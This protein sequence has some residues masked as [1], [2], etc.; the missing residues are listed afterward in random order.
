MTTDETTP[1]WREFM[2]EAALLIESL[3]EMAQLGP[4]S[5]EEAAL[6]NE[7]LRAVS[8]ALQEE[9]SE[10]DGGPVSTD[11]AMGELAEHFA[12]A[13]VGPDQER[14]DL[15]ARLMFALDRFGRVLRERRGEAEP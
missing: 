15:I 5:P 10:D 14:A 3:V 8:E 12:E 2:Q 11:E 13:A 9:L 6:L 1:T 4:L 7:K